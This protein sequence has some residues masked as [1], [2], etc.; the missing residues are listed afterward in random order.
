M[1]VSRTTYCGAST[2]IAKNWCRGLRRNTGFIVLFGSKNSDIN[3]AIARE[4]QLK[5]WRRDWKRSL[6]ESTNPGWLDIYPAL[7]A[8]GRSGHQDIQGQE[9]L[10]P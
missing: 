4:K 2:N 8:T 3:E 7:V 10:H 1:L 5:R 9:T 6:I